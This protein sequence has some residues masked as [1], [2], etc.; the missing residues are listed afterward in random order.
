MAAPDTCSICLSNIDNTKTDHTIT[1]C[2]H[3][4]HSSCILQ[5]T[6]K[7]QK[8][9]SCPN[10]RAQLYDA[11]A[12]VT[13]IN[14]TNNNSNNNP[15]DNSFNLRNI[16]TEFLI[17]YNR[18]INQGLRSNNIFLNESDSDSS[19]DSDH[20][21][22]LETSAEFDE[23]IFHEYKPPSSLISENIQCS[24]CKYTIDL[25]DYPRPKV[26]LQCIHWVHY[27]PCFINSKYNFQKCPQCMSDTYEDTNYNKK[28]YNRLK[29]KINLKI[30]TQIRNYMRQQR[31]SNYNF[32]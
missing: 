2:N 7:N 30:F 6:A 5:Y 12:N 24:I 22:Y 13:T 25:E 1:P 10:C 21:N 18:Q 4:F 9:N 15:Y 19:D 26:K 8:Q 14:N 23:L 31:A 20:S 11:V 32:E 3:K 17:N 27:N 16:I 29:E 28:I